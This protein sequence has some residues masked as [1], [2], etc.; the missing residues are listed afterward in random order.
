MRDFD[1]SK[2]H[3]HD[4]MAINHM[5]FKYPEAK[6]FVAIDNI[7]YNQFESELSKLPCTKHALLGYSDSPAHARLNV[8]RWEWRNCDGFDT[9]PFV[10]HNFNSGLTG[11]N[12]AVNLG[13]TD[14]HLLGFDGDSTICLDAARSEH[15]YMIVK[16]NLIQRQLPDNIR[17]TNHSM[18][19]KIT[20]FQKSEL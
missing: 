15:S 11:I 16:C 6:H 7:V 10:A 3:G 19:S 18:K 5:I 9:S 2:L 13:Y 20:A 8:H 12:I 17:I 4:V 1:Y 14:I